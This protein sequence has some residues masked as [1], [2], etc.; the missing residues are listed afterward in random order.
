MFV[1]PGKVYMPMHVGRMA[2]AWLT[3]GTKAPTALARALAE[4]DH[5]KARAP[6]RKVQVVHALLGSPGA[7]SLGTSLVLHAWLEV[8]VVAGG[9]QHRQCSKFWGWSGGL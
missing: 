4:S 6:T 5:E 9:A 3:H 2:L 1:R 7:H 8:P